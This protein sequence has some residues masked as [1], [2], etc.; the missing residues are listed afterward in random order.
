MATGLFI[1]AGLALFGGF[2]F[3]INSDSAKLNAKQGKTQEIIG[4]VLL[5]LCAA[6][7]FAGYVLQ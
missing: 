2:F 1:L 4:K 3:L 7:G 6:A 5:G